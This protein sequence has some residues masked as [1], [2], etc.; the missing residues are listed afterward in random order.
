MM[1]GGGGGYD[2]TTNTKEANVQSYS[3]FC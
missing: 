3:E 1:M 2:E